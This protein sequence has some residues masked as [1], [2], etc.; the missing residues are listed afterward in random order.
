V[1][2]FTRYVT[3]SYAVNAVILARLTRMYER[4][5]WKSAIAKA[6]TRKLRYFTRSIAEKRKAP[7]IP[8]EASVPEN[9]VSAPPPAPAPEPHLLRS[10]SRVI[11]DSTPLD[12]QNVV[13]P[14]PVQER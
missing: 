3:E 5:D 11:D 13:I 9:P 7:P 8:A 2:I 14:Y 10:N 12:E 4:H 1:I 6:K